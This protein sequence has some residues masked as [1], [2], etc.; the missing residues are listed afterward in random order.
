VLRDLHRLG[1]KIYLDDFG[2]GFTSLGFLHRFPVEAL[3]IDAAL[4]ATLTDGSHGPAIIE[5]IVTLAKTVG[6]HVIAKGVETED[7]VRQLI[8]LGCTDAQ[9]FFFARPLAPHATETALVPQERFD[10]HE[11]DQRALD[12]RGTAKGRHRAA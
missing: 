5:T 11:P 3:K 4:V 10:R 12:K 8:R 2:T 7:Q 1:V 6:T 9:G